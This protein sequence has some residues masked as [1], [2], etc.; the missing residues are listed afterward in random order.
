MKLQKLVYTAFFA[1]LT[2]VGAFISIPLPF[3]PVPI[4]LQT[5][6]VL[7]SGAVL[8]G[9]FGA[10]SQLVYIL[11]GV[12]GLPIFAGAATGPFVLIGPTGGYLIGFVFCAFIVG[13]LFKFAAN[14]NMRFLRYCIIFAIGSV[15]IYAFG[16]AGL[17]LFMHI[18]FKKAVAIGVAPF[19]LGDILKILA[20]AYLG[21][22]VRGQAARDNDQRP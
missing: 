18:S 4:T 8:G 2:A 11:L 19:I 12:I 22:R 15:I 1:A 21:A 14:A 9:V 16:V 20:A 10:L 3:T 6:F 7:L 17:M 13:I 5:L